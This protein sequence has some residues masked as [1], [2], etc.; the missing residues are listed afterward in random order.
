MSTVADLLESKGRMVFSIDAEASVFEA[1]EKMVECDVA[2]L[3]VTDANS[4]LA[5]IIS[6][7][8]FAT[9]VVL[10]DESPRSVQVKDIMTK[11]VL[12]VRDD[13]ATSICMDIM[14]QK[15]F[16]HLPVIERHTPVAMV[17]AGDL[18]RFV[19]REQSMA[20]D[21]LQGYIFDEE[22]GEG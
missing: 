17:T 15:N 16:H 12:Y 5:G 3:V 6:Q 22:G 7:R 8:D 21:E 10:K 1:I 11:N 18:F 2:A 20:I 4:E 14:S 19:V 9:K 13:T